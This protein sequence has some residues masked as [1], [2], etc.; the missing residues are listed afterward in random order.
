MSSTGVAVAS[1]ARWIRHD[2]FLPVI[3]TDTQLS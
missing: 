3:F 2:Q 1:K